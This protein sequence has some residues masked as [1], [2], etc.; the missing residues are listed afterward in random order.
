MVLPIGDDARQQVGPAQERAVGRRHAAEH[1]VIAAAGADMAAV[2]PEFLG[3]QTDLAR[4]LVDGGG[5]GYGMVPRRCRMHVDLDD[6][7][8]GRDLDDIDARV[9]GGAYPSRRMACPVLAAAASIAA[10][11][12]A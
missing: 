8:I 5:D 7:G 6:A 4:F 12:A 9:G 10:I 1:D 11:S 2:Q 3:S